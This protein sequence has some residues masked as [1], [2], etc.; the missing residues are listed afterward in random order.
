MTSFTPKI[1][2]LG[3]DSIINPDLIVSLESGRPGLEH[4]LSGTVTAAE[5][6]AP[7][8]LS[9]LVPARE[10]PSVRSILENLLREKLQSTNSAVVLDLDL[11]SP[12]CGLLGVPNAEGLSDHFLYGLSRDKLLRQSA[13]F[14]GL[15]VITP[16]TFSP[17]AG[18]IYRHRKWKGL[19]DWLAELSG[20][21]IIMLAPPFRVMRK[22]S[23]WPMRLRWCW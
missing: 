5:A 22:S 2:E 8:G 14:P 21:D 13:S 1:T 18:D 15:K 19:L 16:G 6:F 23:H 17:R 3:L 4:G 11:T 9:V 20:A 12:Y 7:A 10:D